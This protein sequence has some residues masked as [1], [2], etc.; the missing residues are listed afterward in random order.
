MRGVMVGGVNR[1]DSR[2]APTLT[3]WAEGSTMARACGSGC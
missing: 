2:I 1:G 3:G